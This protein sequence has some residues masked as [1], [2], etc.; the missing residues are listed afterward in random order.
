MKFAVWLMLFSISFWTIDKDQWVSQ[1]IGATVTTTSINTNVITNVTTM[2]AANGVVITATTYTTRT[3]TGVTVTTNTDG[4]STN[5]G[6][7]ANTNTLCHTG[8][9]QYQGGQ[10]N[11][12]NRD[13]NN[14]QD[15]AQE[16]TNDL[17]NNG[18][19]KSTQ[20]GMAAI[21]A[22][23]AMVAAGMALLPNPPTTPA[24]VALIAAGMALIAAGMAALAA[25]GKMNNNANK[26]QF[27]AG[28]M[29]NLTDP[30]KSTI[31]MDETKKQTGSSQLGDVKKIDLGDGNTS[32]IK[33]DPALLR[34]GKMND[35][36][37][38]L[39]AKT[40]INRDDF[41]K[42]MSSGEN[43]LAMLS[44]SPALAGNASASE[45]NL[46]KMMDD[47]LAK[48]DLPKGDEVMDQLGL[49]AGDLGA[50]GGGGGRAPASPSANI[51]SLFPG[52]NTSGSSGGNPVVA[53]PNAM[54]MSPEV[55]A[56]LDKNGITGRTIFEMVHAQYLKKTPLMF[57]VQERK[58][59]GTAE[60]PYGGL[61]VERINLE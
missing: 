57:G 39:E 22:G 8:G 15:N 52:S 2:T 31:S 48:G 1:A 7:G 37:G 53:D 19:N 30:Y 43:P 18:A 38:D 45:A 9:A 3:Q 12:C 5:T 25:A 14:N 6:T 60:N 49:S 28:K 32:G 4:P 55:Q 33:I 23:M 16:D 59:D 24:G 44:S 40:G 41:A 17:N 29:D 13:K 58:I 50:G 11:Y 26:S 35:I 54:K 42:A 56:A 20:L 61:D 27:N 51:D 10:W 36:Y 34:Q 47:T 21:A 46:Q